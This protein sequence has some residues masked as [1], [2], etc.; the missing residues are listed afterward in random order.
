MS[1]EHLLNA[2]FDLS[3]RQRWRRDRGVVARAEALRIHGLLA[4]DPS[5]SVVLAEPVPGSFLTYL[6]D[7]GIETPRVVVEPGLTRGATFSPF[8]WNDRAAALNQEYLAP[9]LHPP[10]DVVRRVNSRRYAAAVESELEGRSFARGAFVSVGE[11]EQALAAEP[12]RDDGW[13]VKSDFGNAALGNRRLRLRGL[14][15]VDRRFVV[16]LLD[17]D[18]WVVLE[19]WLPRR[20]DLCVTFQVTRDGR[21]AGSHLHEV[22]STSDGAFIG[23]IFSSGPSPLKPWLDEAK[24]VAHDLAGRLAAD[25]YF[26]PVCVDAFV[27]SGGLRRLVDLN[28]RSHV[29][30][31]ALRLWRQ[32]GGA[33]TLYWRLFSSRKL[34][35]PP[36]EFELDRRLGELAFEPH[37]R[38]GALLTSPIRSGSGRP[39]PRIGVCF[40]AA[41]RSEVLAMD[42]AF[43]ERLER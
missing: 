39:L 5:D 34:R 30:A 14:S 25:G 31:P 35:L 2:E 24:A 37:R 7:R 20:L 42:T 27:H 6:D 17:E 19:P 23:A 26:G 32:W 4:G 41:T 13:V 12:G 40:A 1:R 15:E 36:S 18:D 28:A 10:L 43:R 33:R 38:H 29:S 21:A 16:S 11:L 8:G 9:S 3:L 22:V